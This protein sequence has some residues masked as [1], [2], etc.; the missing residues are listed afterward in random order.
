METEVKQ[1]TSNKSKEIF[2]SIHSHSLIFV[3]AFFNLHIY[4]EYISVHYFLY[5]YFVAAY[6]INSYLYH[7]YKKKVFPI[8]TLLFL[9]NREKC[10]DF[11]NHDCCNR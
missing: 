6:K 11:Y 7:I 9:P 2:S 8:V 4:K 10:R 5:I 3:E 1:I